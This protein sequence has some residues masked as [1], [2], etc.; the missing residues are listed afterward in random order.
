MSGC[1]RTALGAVDAVDEIVDAVKGLD[2][3]TAN[4]AEGTA[5]VPVAVAFAAGQIAKR[6]IRQSVKML[7]NS[8]LTLPPTTAT[9]KRILRGFSVL[10]FGD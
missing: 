7:R 9:R 3:H 5:P 8:R 2:R 10:T 6:T 1:V 4:G